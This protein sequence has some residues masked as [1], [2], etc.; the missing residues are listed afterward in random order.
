MNMENIAEIIG[1]A[2]ALLFLLSYIILQHKR[3]FAKTVLY[4]VI[5]LLAAFLV[6]YSTMYFWNPAAF[7]NNTFWLIISFYGIVK[8]YS[9]KKEILHKIK[10][11]NPKDL[12]H[13]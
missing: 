4:S 7:I 9:Q 8:S 1:I 3:D 11:P 13:Q 12:I 6:L 5:N 10:Q 2:G